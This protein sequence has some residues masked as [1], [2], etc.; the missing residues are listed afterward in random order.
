MNNHEEQRVTDIEVQALYKGGRTQ[1]QLGA[2]A[3]VIV[4]RETNPAKVARICIRKERTT[5]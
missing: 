4:G 2:R 5:C 3:K 1:G